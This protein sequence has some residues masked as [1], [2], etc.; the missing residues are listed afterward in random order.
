MHAGVPAA[1]YKSRAN[2]MQGGF[3]QSEEQKMVDAR[4]EQQKELLKEL[5][6]WEDV[7]ESNFYFT[8]LKVIEILC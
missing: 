6:N 8:K 1:I 7:T 5:K 2:N 4:E 3:P